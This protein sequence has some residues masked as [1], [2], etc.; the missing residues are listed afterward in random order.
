VISKNANN[1]PWR[2]IV[3]NESSLD[4][5][6][7]SDEENDQNEG[8]KKKVATMASVGPEPEAGPWSAVAK[9]LQYVV[10]LWVSFFQYLLLKPFIKRSQ[11]FIGL[12]PSY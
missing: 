3:G 8:T 11:S 6:K 2:K 10:S 4:V 9:C 12:T 7:Y 5:E 1:I